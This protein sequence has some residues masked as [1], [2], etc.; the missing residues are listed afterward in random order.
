MKRKYKR[1]SISLVFPLL[2]AWHYVIRLDEVPDI[3]HIILLCAITVLVSGGIYLCEPVAIKIEY[4]S[5]AYALVL[6]VAMLLF[7]IGLP[8]YINEPVSDSSN[9]W[10]QPLMFFACCIPVIHHSYRYQHLKS[11]FI[12]SQ[13]NA[14]WSG[15]YA[16]RRIEGSRQVRR[17][18]PSRLLLY[19]IYCEFVD[20]KLEASNQN[21]WSAARD[22]TRE[23]LR[24]SKKLLSQGYSPLCK[25]LV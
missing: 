17:V 18:G 16:W 14:D 9:P 5:P 3:G 12:K 19:P 15:E 21:L 22:S 4:K 7:I 25:S 20:S 6:G 11:S 13:Q 10:A 2:A 24:N 1:V 23:L 8:S